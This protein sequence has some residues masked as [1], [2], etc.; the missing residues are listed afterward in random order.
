MSKI[1]YVLLAIISAGLSLWIA[2]Q[3]LTIS[4]IKLLFSA[5]EY[6]VYY[7]CGAIAFTGAMSTW[8]LANDMAVW[9]VGAEYCID[10]NEVPGV[11]RTRRIMEELNKSFGLPELPRLAIYPGQDINAIVVARSRSSSTIAVSQALVERSSDAQIRTIVAYCLAKIS[12]GGILPLLLIQGSLMAFTLFPARMFALL[13]G[14]SLRT[15]DEDTPSDTVERLITASL[16]VI[17]VPFSALL[18]RFYSRYCQRR[19]DQ[20]VAQLIGRG[21]MRAVLESLTKE[22]SPRAFREA[23]ALPHKF[24]MSILPRMRIFSFHRSYQERAALS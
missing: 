13:L 3:F 12:S 2:D 4:G 22:A 21:E 10:E 5:G 19:T 20:I 11:T 6:S 24:G 9:S 18:I 1:T 15:A 23:Y 16:E 17:L 14:T 8:Y 7:W